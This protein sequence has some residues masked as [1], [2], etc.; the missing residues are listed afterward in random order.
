MDQIVLL[1]INVIIVL[2]THICANGCAAHFHDVNVN[3]H[4]YVNV[5]VIA[6][7]FH[8]NFNFNVHE[9]VDVNVVIVVVLAA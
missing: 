6:N 4:D 3:V 9:Y 2:L 5:N 1:F 7:D 8:V